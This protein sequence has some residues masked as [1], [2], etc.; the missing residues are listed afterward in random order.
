MLSRKRPMEMMMSASPHRE[1]SSQVL[2]VQSQSKS[3]FPERKRKRL[4]PKFRD[5]NDE[6]EEFRG[7]RKRRGN[8]MA[9]VEQ[10]PTKRLHVQECHSGPLKRSFEHAQ[11]FSS[12]K[13]C[14]LEKNVSENERRLY[15]EMEVHNIKQA[16][17]AQ[18]I[19]LRHQLQV[20]KHELQT[21]GEQTTILKRGL[22]R[23]NEKLEDAGREN[24]NLKH[25]NSN[26]KQ[27]VQM[28]AIQ[29]QRL[30]EENNRLKAELLG[31]SCSGANGF[32]PRVPPGVH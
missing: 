29:N 30:E 6:N 27:A 7:S 22:I 31:L 24:S 11:E 13:R 20:A 5:R 18:I 16:H 14:R 32:F 10:Q 15:S 19:T 25:E 1:S 9:I 4:M 3:Q 21:V 17:Y 26:L 2:G 23:M 8:E 12:R 28:M